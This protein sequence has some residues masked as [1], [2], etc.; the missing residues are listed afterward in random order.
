MAGRLKKEVAVPQDEELCRNLGKRIQK[1][2]NGLAL[3][4]LALFSITMTQF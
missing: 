2:K 1:G 4:L 3:L